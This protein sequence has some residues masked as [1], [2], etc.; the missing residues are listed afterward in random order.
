MLAEKFHIATEP[1]LIFSAR[2][3]LIAAGGVTAK[4][5]GKTAAILAC[6]EL[7]GVAVNISFYKI[8]MILLT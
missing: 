4:D 2:R 1:E 6:Y 3:A 7:L 8:F 5:A